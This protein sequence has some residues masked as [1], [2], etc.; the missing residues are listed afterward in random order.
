[1]EIA[2]PENTEV[3]GSHYNLTWSKEE[4][5]KGGGLL[6]LANSGS[7]ELI[8]KFLEKCLGGSDH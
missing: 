2:S 6:E 5:G 4:G 1:M 8:D 7:Q 3:G